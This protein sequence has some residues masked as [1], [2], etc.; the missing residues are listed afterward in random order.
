MCVNLSFGDLYPALAPL[1][2]TNIYTYEMTIAPKV[3]G[4]QI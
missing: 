2:P 3:C 4:G 1:H